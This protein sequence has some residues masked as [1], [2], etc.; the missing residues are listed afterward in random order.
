MWNT[1]AETFRDAICNARDTVE[2]LLADRSGRIL[3]AYLLFGLC[4]VIVGGVLIWLHG[5]GSIGP[6]ALVLAAAN[7]AHAVWTHFD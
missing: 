3:A 5:P 6:A 4:C 7:L 2:D 1:V